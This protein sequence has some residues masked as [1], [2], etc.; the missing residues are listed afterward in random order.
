MPL[1]KAANKLD[2]VFEISIILKAVDGLI[3]TAGGVLLLLVNPASITNWATRITQHELSTD[4]HDFIAR[5]ILHSA[6]NF[7]SGGR[8]FAAVYLLIHGLSKI[9]LV[10]EILREH[11]WAYRGM[12]VLLGLFIIY[13]VYRMFYEPAIWLVVLTVFD[14]F[15]IY[16]TIREEKRQ[17]LALGKHSN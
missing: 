4:P 6:Q 13:Q 5:H 8:T 3:E 9:V 11:L 15:V 16:L 7:A 14:A 17:R 10:V 1:F 2:R 12:I